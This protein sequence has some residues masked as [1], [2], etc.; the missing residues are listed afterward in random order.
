MDRVRQCSADPDQAVLFFQQILNPVPHIRAQAI[1][2]PWI[3]ETVSRMFSE[4]GTGYA[5]VDPIMMTGPDDSWLFG[6]PKRSKTSCSTRLSSC[7]KWLPRCGCFSSPEV[8][9]DCQ[10]PCSPQTQQTAQ[11]ASQSQ[12]V[13]GGRELGCKSG[14]RGCFS[15]IRSAL[16]KNKKCDSSSAIAGSVSGRDSSV[17]TSSTSGAAQDA[18]S[19]ACQQP[20]Q[21]E[22]VQTCK[23][24]PGAAAVQVTAVTANG[25]LLQ[26]QQQQQQQEAAIHE[27]FGPDTPKIEP[28]TDR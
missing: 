3:A 15:R 26:Q 21:A 5:P 4:T 18:A 11:Q 24:Q 22:A 2:H 7:A 6:K 16:S 10:N 1:H 14:N 25:S 23:T 28:S 20:E 12:Q 13:K 19:V 17:P 9:K 8:Q 27:V